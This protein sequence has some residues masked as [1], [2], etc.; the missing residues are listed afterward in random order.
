MLMTKASFLNNTSIFS[1]NVVLFL[2]KL[3][4]K[5]PWDN[6]ETIV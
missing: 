3:F 2:S 6:D 4:R 1:L 5:S